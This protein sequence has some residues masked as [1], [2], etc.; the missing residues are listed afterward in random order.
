MITLE[1]LKNYQD[2][3][4][5]LNLEP[6]IIEARLHQSVVIYDSIYLDNLLARAVINYAGI[7][8]FEMNQSQ[9]YELP[10]PCQSL[11][12]SPDGFPLWAT[13]V[14]IPVG[15][16]FKDT[17]YLHKRLD[18]FEFSEKQPKSNVGR[19]VSRRMP[20]PIFQ[21]ETKRW[22]A[23][24]IG[25]A[26]YIRELLKEIHGLGKHRNIGFG[27]VSE[28]S[29]D[30]WDGDAID[31]IIQDEKLTHALPEQAAHDLGFEISAPTS[32][33][34]WTPP[35]WSPILFRMGWPIGTQAKRI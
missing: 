13:S 19:W 18:K 6:L 23:F 14:F 29:V 2:Q 33:V 24:C 9:C 17:L 10:I 1:K 20:K 35:Q 21:S 34:G 5:A 4:D 16:V 12:R 22:Q 26:E 8:T 11:W 27:E 28:W 15:D 7:N 30:S 3:F 31:T 25:N 32:L